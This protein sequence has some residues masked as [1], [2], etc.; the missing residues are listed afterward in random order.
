MKPKFNR[1]KEVVI[2]LA[3]VVAKEDNYGSIASL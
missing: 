3:M 2:S 1:G